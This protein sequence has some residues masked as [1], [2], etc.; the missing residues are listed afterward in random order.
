MSSAVLTSEQ[1][2][3]QEYARRWLGRSNSYALL[4]K[5]PMPTWFF[6]GLLATFLILVLIDRRRG[7]PLA[8]GL[9]KLLRIRIRRAPAEAEV[10]P[11]VTPVSGDELADRIQEFYA[12]EDRRRP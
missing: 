9:A 7:F 12:E 5:R 10:A 8:R 3:F 6:P 2:E 1:R 11:L 4:S